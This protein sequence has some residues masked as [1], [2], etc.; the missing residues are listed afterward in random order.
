MEIVTN[1]KACVVFM[2]A[3][4]GA[5]GMLRVDRWFAANGRMVT[6]KASQ[7]C[8]LR[9]LQR[10]RNKAVTNGL[11]PTYVV[12]KKL[13]E[14]KLREAALGLVANFEVQADLRPRGDRWPFEALTVRP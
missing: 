3:S 14:G 7:R 6:G 8:P 4:P 1:A 5:R 2:I 11:P 9:A 13:R 12:R 10:R